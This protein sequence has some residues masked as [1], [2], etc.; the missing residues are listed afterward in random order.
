MPGDSVPLQDVFCFGV[1]GSMLS[2]AKSSSKRK[3][4]D[5]FTEG[6]DTEC[7]PTDLIQQWS[8]GHKWQHSLCK[9][10][11]ND[12]K[13]FV[14]SRRSRKRKESISAGISWD[15][16]PDELIL[17]IL[18]LLP[19]QDLL[20]TSVICRRWHRLAFDESLWQSVDLEGVSNMGLALQQVLKTGVRRLRCPRS[21]INNLHLTGTCTLQ[22]AEMDLSSSI[23]T[24]P[25]LE[26]ILCSCNLIECLSLEGLQLSDNII[27]SLAQN[28]RLRQLNLSG[29]SD[30][31]AQPL[32]H[33]LQSC[34]RIEQLNIS[35]CH[36]NSNHV[37]S[38]VN[39]VSSNVTHL[40]LSGYRDGLTLDDVKALVT[41]CPN[42]HTLDL[43][44]STQLMADCF[45][46]LS[47]LKHLHHLS[48]SRC[49]H[50]HIASLTDLRKTFPKLHYL[51]V[52]GLVNDSHL[53]SL[54]K[55][56]PGIC[57]NS[58]P[59]SAVARPTPASVLGTVGGYSMWNRKNRLRFTL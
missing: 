11:E 36:F 16:F 4:Q 2:R 39:H 27:S 31:S 17:R 45:P 3:C 25:I 52:F 41:R 49:Y 19:L 18:I 58:L 35:W 13:P 59:F 53:S 50:I 7:T 24:T 51:E 15:H 23:I 30:F 26:S 37:K 10:K 28:W 22:V 54:R 44:D 34:T 20:K 21:F 38:V 42:I 5:V 33:M 6:L 32:G 47:E 40:N 43:S 8:P 14:I 56:N 48:L 12:G 46:V 57:I 9:G 1:Q 29:C 55:E